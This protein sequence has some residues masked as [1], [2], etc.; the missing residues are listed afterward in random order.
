MFNFLFRPPEFGDIYFRVKEVRVLFDFCT[1]C[2]QTQRIYLRE[3]SK[4]DFSDFCLAHVFTYRDFPQ[5]IQGLAWRSTFC[6]RV[7]NTGFTT[8]LNHQVCQKY[9][10]HEVMALV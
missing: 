1:E 5:G 2:N 8:L 9:R 10:Q 3:F 6:R 4:M 7:Y